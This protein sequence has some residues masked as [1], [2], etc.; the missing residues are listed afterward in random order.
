M[1]ALTVAAVSGLLFRFCL[2]FLKLNDFS[3]SICVNS[4][5]FI[6]Y[7]LLNYSRVLGTS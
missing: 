2:F 5:N 6:Y 7:E 3:I 1:D 4:V